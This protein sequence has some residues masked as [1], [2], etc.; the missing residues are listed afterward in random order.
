MALFSKTGKKRESATKELSKPKALTYQLK[1]GTVLVPVVSEKATRLQQ[2]GQYMFKVVG[3]VTKVEAKKA[4]ESAFGVRVLGVN[5]LGLPGKVVRRG[6]KSGQ[7]SGRRHLVVRV[8]KG[9]SID[10][11]KSL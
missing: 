9:E 4:V 5:S 8:A 11:G 2:Q 10:L 6:R 1:P 7:R 3:R